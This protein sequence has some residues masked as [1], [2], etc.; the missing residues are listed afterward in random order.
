MN[1]TPLIWSGWK[2]DL[3]GSGTTGLVWWPS[4]QDLPNAFNRFMQGILLG[5]RWTK[6]APPGGLPPHLSAPQPPVK[7]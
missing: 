5:N 6:V 4:V 7:L 3:F 2:C 1:D